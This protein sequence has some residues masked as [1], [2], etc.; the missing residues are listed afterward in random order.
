MTN[1]VEQ[2]EDARARRERAERA[3]RLLPRVTRARRM[4]SNVIDPNALEP[5]QAIKPRTI[6]VLDASG[7]NEKQADIGLNYYLDTVFEDRKE[8]VLGKKSDKNRD[9]IFNSPVLFVIEE[10]HT[11]IKHDGDTDTKST[12]GRI[13]AQ[14]RK[15]GLGLCIVSQRPAKVDEDILSQM[16]SFVVLKLI[17]KRDQDIIANT[18]E[19][20]T[21]SLARQ[22]S[23]L[24]NEYK[25]RAAIIIAI[26]NNIAKKSL[27][28]K[29]S[30]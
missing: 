27:A 25:P 4:Y 12:A 21:D 17:Q 9:V 8:A 19:D 2:P 1:G 30:G 14:A 29:L 26:K 24:N 5:K 6:N 20:I 22:L 11:F 7:F 10:A 3:R 15:F 18:S 28:K 16:G 23:S 13:A